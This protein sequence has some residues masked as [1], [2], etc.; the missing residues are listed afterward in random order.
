[1]AISII[2]NWRQHS[3]NGHAAP[4]VSP[5]AAFFYNSFYRQNWDICF[6][7][8]LNF[9]AHSSSEEGSAIISQLVYIYMYHRNWSIY[10]QIFIQIFICGNYIFTIWMRGHREGRKAEITR[11]QQKQTPLN[12]SS[13]WHLREPETKKNRKEIK[14]R[15]EKK[16]CDR[17]E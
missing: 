1:M 4:D 8:F 9:E 11:S 14:D 16:V 5:Q 12:S 13:E 6:D 10:I 17:F 2:A 3:G 7:L 15:Y